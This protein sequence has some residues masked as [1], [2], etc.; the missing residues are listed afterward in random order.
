MNKDS[1]KVHI[2]ITR[3]PKNT[4][5]CGKIPDDSGEYGNADRE[6]KKALIIS[7]AEALLTLSLAFCAGAYC[8]FGN[9]K[10]KKERKRNG[11]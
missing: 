7:R 10:N 1:K 9:R 4:P 3:V 11:R 5:L 6:A 2:K 8:L